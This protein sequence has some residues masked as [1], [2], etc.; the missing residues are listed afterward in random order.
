MVLKRLLS[1][2]V[3]VMMIGTDMKVFS[4]STIGE[5]HVK[6]GKPCQDYSLSDQ[7]YDCSLS[8]IIVSDGHGG[9]PY[10]RSHIGSEKACV[11][12]WIASRNL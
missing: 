12:P 6:D 11:W 4:K 2:I 9:K 8:V 1:W 7:A 5:G 3:V 10:F